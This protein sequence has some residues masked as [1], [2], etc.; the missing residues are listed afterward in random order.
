MQKKR[1]NQKPTIFEILTILFEKNSFVWEI[2][3]LLS[4]VIVAILI[5]R[6]FTKDGLSPSTLDK[7]SVIALVSFAF[8]LIL[9]ATRLF[10]FLNN[11]SSEKKSDSY[12]TIVLRHEILESQKNI[13]NTIKEALHKNP[14]ILNVEKSIYEKIVTN[15]EGSLINKLDA[16]FQ[17]NIKSEFIITS[18]INELNPLT[19]NIEKYI[20]RIQRNSI[21]NLFIGIVGTITAITILAFAILTN[22][23]FTNLQDFFIHFLPRF[24]FVVFIQ[25]FAFF[26]LKL[27]KNNL[28]DAKYFQNEL[29]NLTAKS[30]AIKISY[31]MGNTEKVAE[32]IKELSMTERNFKLLKDE[33]TMGLER[34]KIDSEFE[35][36][37]IDQFKGII[38]KYEPKK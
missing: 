24:T 29:T 25:L 10:K 19:K 21:V 35:K 32:V 8:I 30:S 16:R 37:I 26:F 1:K 33:T 20:D 12:S 27:Y 18:I 15:L 6:L 34:A 28:E 3:I 9:L 23:Q 14:E 4:G 22:K 5:P 11:D 17:N 2:L 36:T 13:E 38:S 7:S 31:L